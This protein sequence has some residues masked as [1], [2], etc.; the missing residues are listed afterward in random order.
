[1]R[2]SYNCLSGSFATSKLH[3]ELAKAKAEQKKLL[4]T[5]SDGATEALLV[6]ANLVRFQ[7]AEKISL[8]EMSSS[9]AF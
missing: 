4:S 2:A 5:H 6:S 3:S 7:C 9:L 1:M 8:L